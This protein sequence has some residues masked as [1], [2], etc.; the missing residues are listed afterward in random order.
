MNWLLI[1]AI[2]LVVLWVAAEVLGWVLGAALH[3]L[4]IAALVLLAVWVV[5]KI[6]RRV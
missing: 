5:G 1:F 3:L 2:A 6:R 4:W